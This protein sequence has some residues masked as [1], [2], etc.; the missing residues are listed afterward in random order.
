M[1]KTQHTLETTE[2]IAGGKLADARKKGMLPGVCY[3]NKTQALPFFLDRIDFQK[4][5]K[6]AGGSSIVTIVVNNKND[7]S[8]LLLS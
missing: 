1:S 7:N 2:R 5:Y 6:S 8:D 3:G 4:V